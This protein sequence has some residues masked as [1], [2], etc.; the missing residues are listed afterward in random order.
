MGLAKYSN[1]FKLTLHP[2]SL[3]MPRKTRKP[4]LIFVNSMS[5]LFHKDVPLEFIKEVFSVMNS[6][7][8]HIFQV[9]TKRHERLLEVAE[10]LEW[11]G[12][13]WMGVTV[14]NRDAVSRIEY[15]R[16]TPAK[17]KFISAEPLIGDLGDINLSGMGWVIAG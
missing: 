11:G 10:E 13:I 16:K 14:E 12:N 3:D 6:E 15:L 7:S 4:A 2:E 5:D 17:L 8:R 1:A 9:L